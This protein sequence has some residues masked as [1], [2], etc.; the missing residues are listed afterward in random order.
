MSDPAWIRRE[1]DA[2]DNVLAGLTALGLAAVVGA[3][4]FYLGRLLLSREPLRLEPPEV[5]DAPRRSGLEPGT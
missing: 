2:R 4:A 1:P 3:S 5:P